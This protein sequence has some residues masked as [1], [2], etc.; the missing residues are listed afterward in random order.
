MRSAQGT[1]CGRMPESNLPYPIGKFSSSK[2]IAQTADKPRLFAKAGFYFVVE[3]IAD[4]EHLEQLYGIDGG[5]TVVG[6]VQMRGGVADEVERD[7]AVDQT[8]QVIRRNQLF[9]GDHFQPVLVGGGRFEHAQNSNTKP[10]TRGGF[11]SSLKRPEG[12]LLLQSKAFP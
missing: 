1:S 4:E 12:R 7:M 6:A 5:V 8:K 10:P 3:E 9:E 11:V 2:T